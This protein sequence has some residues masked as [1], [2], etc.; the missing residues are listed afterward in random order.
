MD[1]IWLMRFLWMMEKCFHVHWFKFC[2]SMKHDF[3]WKATST[4]QLSWLEG[5]LNT[6]PGWHKHAWICMLLYI[7]IWWC[8][9]KVGQI[10]PVNI[11]DW[12]SISLQTFQWA[13]ME[14]IICSLFIP[15]ND[16]FPSCHFWVCQWCHLLWLL[17]KSCVNVTCWW[18]DKCVY[19]NPCAIVFWNVLKKR[20]H[21][22]VLCLLAFL[23]FLHGCPFIGIDRSINPSCRI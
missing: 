20:M 7:L 8:T 23:G 3:Q 9:W 22:L 18:I 21:H 17:H 1:E 6:Q 5:T 11:L 14:M 10:S 16:E 2:L 12:W 15:I 4:I 13:W 19:G